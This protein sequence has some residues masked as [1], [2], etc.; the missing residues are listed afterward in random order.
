MKSKVIIIALLFAC[1]VSFTA[2]SREKSSSDNQQPQEPAEIRDLVRMYFTDAA[3]RL[4]EPEYAYFSNI[5]DHQAFLRAHRDEMLKTLEIVDVTQTD[6]IAV[7]F[8]RYSVGSN[9]YREGVW[10]RRVDGRWRV[11]SSQY[12]SSFGDDPFN[13]GK[14]DEAKK[15]IKR[16]DDWEKDAKT[17][18]R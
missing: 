4:P 16:L 11:C 12:F 15:L 13:D 14:P 3:W 5:F 6:K 8:V 9:V 2:C 18:W 10:M 7:A 17:W 1:A